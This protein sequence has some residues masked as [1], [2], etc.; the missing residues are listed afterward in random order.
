M[1]RHLVLV[2]LASLAVA[3]C[4]GGQS[5]QTKE[6]SALAGDQSRGVP[7]ATRAERDWTEAARGHGAAG[8]IA[9]EEL[10]RM[11]RLSAPGAKVQADAGSSSK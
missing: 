8:P 11:D 7:S 10:A 6:E 2:S 5:K 9:A 3:A 1:K 4:L